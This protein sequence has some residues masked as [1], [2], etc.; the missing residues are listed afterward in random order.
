MKIMKIAF[1]ISLIFFLVG[2][3]FSGFSQEKKEKIIIR[4]VVKTDSNLPVYKAKIF[5]D[6][7]KI[8][9]RTNKKGF[10][11]I[12]LPKEPKKIKFRSKYGTKTIEYKG[13]NLIN[14]TYSS[15]KVKDKRKYKK[16]LTIY[17]YLRGQPGVEVTGTRVFIR[18]VSSLNGSTEPLYI[19]DGST[20][21]SFNNIN[22]LD[23][24]K[25]KVL[26]TPDELSIYG[27]RGGNGVIVIDTFS[28]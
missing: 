4:G 3:S 28:K 9:R 20:V 8:N 18:G 6:G 26:K 22:M 24:K 17:D 27:T 19:I 16:F 10:Y 1:K 7:K 15:K 11:T 2:L 23:V 5:V 25:I 13:I 21:N 14:V 12:V